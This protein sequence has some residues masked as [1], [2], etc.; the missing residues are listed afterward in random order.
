[1]ETYLQSQLAAFQAS[2][3]LP[4]NPSL[5]QDPSLSYHHL[6]SSPLSAEPI[7]QAS[8]DFY[9]DKYIHGLEERLWL[10]QELLQRDGV[11]KEKEQLLRDALNHASVLEAKIEERNR[12]VIK[13]EEVEETQEQQAP[14]VITKE[15]CIKSTSTHKKE[16][17]LYNVLST[18][19]P[20]QKVKNNGSATAS[21]HKKSPKTP[22]STHN[23]SHQ[24]PL[25][26][27]SRKKVKPKSS[28]KDFKDFEIPGMK[29]AAVEKK[30]PRI[31]FLLFL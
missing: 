16:K 6:P 28:T 15:S 10:F 1:M 13:Q 11:L 8:V 26:S 22:I 4:I 9:K 20:L 5:G 12:L 25:M 7:T 19:T 30:P 23:D 31:L 21:S 2:M 14:P 17:P 24:T 27:S 29:S 18:P 3:P